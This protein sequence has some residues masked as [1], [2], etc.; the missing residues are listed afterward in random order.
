MQSRIGSILEK[1]L[2]KIEETVR[3]QEEMVKNR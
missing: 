3:L 2:F 1:H